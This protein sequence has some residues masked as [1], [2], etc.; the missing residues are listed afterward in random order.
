M[1][2]RSKVEGLLKSLPGKALKILG[3]GS[4]SKVFYDIGKNVILGLSNGIRQNADIPN[5]SM[6]DL[7]GTVVDTVSTIPDI[8]DGL[9][10]LD[11][12]I[13]PVLDLTQVQNGV[14]QMNSMLAPTPIVPATSSGQASSISASQAAASADETVPNSGD[15]ASITFQQNNYSPESLSE[16]DIYRQ[17]KNQLAQARNVLVPT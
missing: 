12:T 15:L 5:N 2:F 4:P 6:E 8:L 3:I 17:T 10:D 16:I 9:V 14:T 11:P 1:L 7:V 13:T